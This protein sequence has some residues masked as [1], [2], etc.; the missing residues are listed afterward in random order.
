MRELTPDKEKFLVDYC[1]EPENTSV[2]LAV[3]QVQVQIRERILNSF[4]KDL[5]VR[6][7]NRLEEPPPAW[8][9]CVPETNLRRWDGREDDWIYKITMGDPEIMIGLY[10]FGVGRGLIVPRDLFLGTPGEYE[11]C[12]RAENLRGSWERSHLL[13]RQNET[14]HG[15]ELWRWFF[16]PDEGRGGL[17]ELSTL[18]DDGGRSEKLEYYTEILLHSARAISDTLKERG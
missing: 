9:T 2:A 16:Y 1:M 8:S 7:R 3:G 10:P 18:Q 13:K 4:L 6:L 14:L 12:P 15:N 17:E 11:G 5:D